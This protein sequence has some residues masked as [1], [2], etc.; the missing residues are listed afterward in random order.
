MF[1]GKG[2]LQN[3][4]NTKKS[5]CN[6]KWKLLFTFQLVYLLL[7]A[8]KFI[9]EGLS[10]KQLII[11]VTALKSLPPSAHFLHVWPWPLTHWPWILINSSRIC[12]KYLCKSW[13]ESVWELWKNNWGLANMGRGAAGAEGSGVWGGV[14]LWNFLPQNSEFLRLFW[15]E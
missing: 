1:L 4:L 13:F 9:E 14:G 2:F 3:F 5:N 12:S 10:F 8:S 6:L 15:Q 11:D 7:Y